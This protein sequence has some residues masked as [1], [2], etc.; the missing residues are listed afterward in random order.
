MDFAKLFYHNFPKIINYLLI[1]LI[2]KMLLFFKIYYKFKFKF[3]F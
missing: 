3:Y 2:D 1:K